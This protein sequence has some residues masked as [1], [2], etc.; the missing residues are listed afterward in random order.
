M[1][2]FRVGERDGC[3]DSRQIEIG[4][5]NRDLSTKPYIVIVIPIRLEIVMVPMSCRSQQV[6]ELGMVIERMCVQVGRA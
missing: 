1:D 4:P 5:K 3:E 2:D 6:C